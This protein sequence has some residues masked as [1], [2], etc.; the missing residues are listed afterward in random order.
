MNKRSDF[1]VERDQLGE[2]QIPSGA[3][4]GIQTM[5]A[6]QNFTISGLAPHPKLIETCVILKK[7]AAQLNVEE[8]YISLQMGKAIAQAA[9]E[10]LNGQLRDQF[11]VDPFQS[12]CGCAHISNVNEV[13]AN[14]AA[15]IL[16]GQCGTYTL[17][18]PDEHVSAQQLPCDVFQTATRMAILLVF[19]DLEHALLDL[20]RLLRRK[21]LEFDRIVKVGRLQLRDSLPVTLGQ[22]FNAYG[23]AIEHSS[24]HLR[25][26]SHSLCEL[27]IGSSPVGP[28]FTVDYHRIGRMVERLCQMTGLPLK[29]GDDL[30]RLCQ[31]ASDFLEFS[32]NLRQLA[33]EL[34]KIGN[35]LRLLSSGPNAGFGE[36]NLPPVVLH[37]HAAS[38]FKLPPH[39]T[40]GLLE[41]LAMASYQVVGNDSTV[42]LAA[43]S[44]QLEANVMTPLIAHNVLQSMDLLTNAVITLNKHCISGITANA[45]RCK[46]LLDSTDAPM[47]ALASAIGI[48]DA[49]ALAEEA[50]AERKS[51]RQVALE[52]GIM[53][54]DQL[55]KI[56]SCKSLTQPVT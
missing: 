24:R 32:A 27:N 19:R 23:S 11:I 15:E 48:E 34:L 21:A 31:S 28:S 38:R 33:V 26:S 6:R 44:G 45:A 47:L 8:G 35:D 53:P 36:L 40:P 42:M 17:V 43:Q 4:W 50:A 2:M 1:R 18:N 12:G 7:A 13:L 41:C 46:E 56:L 49:A 16:G 14:R 55:D 5:R 51:L 9:D 10:I 25:Q 39:A 3:Y 20:E 29:A 37:P 22:E 54:P 30:G 52:K